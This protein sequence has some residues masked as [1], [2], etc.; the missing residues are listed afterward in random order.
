MKLLPFQRFAI[1]V[2]IVDALI[3]V[4]TMLPGAPLVPNVPVVIALMLSVAVLV[5][6]I[7]KFRPG[8]LRAGGLKALFRALRESLP[9]GAIII[10][11]IAFYGGWL[12]ALISIAHSD[13][14][15]NL[16]Y[17]NGRYTSTQKKVVR[18]L[19]KEQYEAAHAL[20]Q[21]AFSAS[22]LG[23]VSGS[24]VLTAVARRIREGQG[25]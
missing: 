20:N 22:A 1:G 21:R 25:S 7:V 3:V 9:V 10:A 8:A 6:M 5:L 16:K 11:A 15:S 18:V 4:S 24:F 17:E 2:G 14:A 23:L 19:T 12:I 13:F